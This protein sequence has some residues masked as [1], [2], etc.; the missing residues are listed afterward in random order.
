MTRGNLHCGGCGCLVASLAVTAALLQAACGLFASGLS[1]TFGG[2][3]VAQWQCTVSP[4]EVIVCCGQLHQMR[5]VAI[6][7]LHKCTTWKAHA[8]HVADTSGT[9]MYGVP[10]PVLFPSSQSST[11]CN[12]Y[13][14]RKASKLL[15]LISQED[16]SVFCN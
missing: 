12:Y 1:R 4:S 2:P 15:Q 7:I 6:S 14:I 16:C 13:H 3:L 10:L 9:Y 8:A 5:Q 11:L